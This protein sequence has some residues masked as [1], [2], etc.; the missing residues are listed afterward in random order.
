MDGR[1]VL[2]NRVSGLIHEGVVMS[3]VTQNSGRLSA[4]TLRG[5]HESLTPRPQTRRRPP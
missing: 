5:A 3:I 4:A 1:R 2:L